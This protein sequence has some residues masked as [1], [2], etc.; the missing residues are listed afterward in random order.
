MKS[1][2]MGVRE[3]V[4]VAAAAVRRSKRRKKQTKQRIGQ[5]VAK[6]FGRE[7]YYGEVTAFEE[8]VEDS[9]AQWHIEYNDGDEEDFYEEDLE[10][11]I[12]LWNEQQNGSADD[13]G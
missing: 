4:E 13:E 5:G 6:L 12:T 10:K 1:V 3:V 2:C 9:P 8:E 7:V 11:A